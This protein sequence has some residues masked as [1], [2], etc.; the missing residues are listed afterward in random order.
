[1][2][3][4]TKR[5]PSITVVQHQREIDEAGEPAAGHEGVEI[6]VVRIFGEDL[7][8]LQRPDAERPVER[9]L[10]PRT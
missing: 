10:A 3:T 1:M 5:K 8:E 9:E 2:R 6:G 4:K 7:V